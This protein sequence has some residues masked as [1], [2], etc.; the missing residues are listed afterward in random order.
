M[1]F[2]EFEVAAHRKRVAHYVNYL[3]STGRA[4]CLADV[5]E[6]FGFCTKD[7]QSILINA[8]ATLAAEVPAP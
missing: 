1:T 3:N 7:A 5:K 8:V 4:P 2:T 6:I